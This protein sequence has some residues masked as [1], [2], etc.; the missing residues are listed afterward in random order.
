[1][2]I[3]SVVRE[4]LERA[5]RG[6]FYPQPGPGGA[7]AYPDLGRYSAFVDDLNS[8]VRA[9]GLLYPGCKNPRPW[10]CRVWG[11]VYRRVGLAYNERFAAG[12]T[13]ARVTL[14]CC[15]PPNKGRA[16]ASRNEAAL[17]RKQDAAAAAGRFEDAD[18]NPLPAAAPGGGAAPEPYAWPAD[19][20]GADWFRADAAVQCDWEGIAYSADPRPKLRFYEALTRYLLFEMPLPPS[21]TLLLDCGVLD[22]RWVRQPMRVRIAH[23]FDPLLVTDADVRAALQAGTPGVARRVEFATEHEAPTGFGEADDRMVYHVYDLT[24]RCR[25]SVVVFSGDG[26]TDVAL[27]NTLRVRRALQRSARPEL[28]A[29]RVPDDAP[30]PAVVHAMPRARQTTDPNGARRDFADTIVI[31]TDRLA[32]WLEVHY[33][34]GALA[35]QAGR[36]HPGRVDG[37]AMFSLLVALRTT[38]YTEA[39]PFLSLPNILEAHE[40]TPRLLADALETHVVADPELC[41]PFTLIDCRLHVPSFRRF[42]AAAIAVACENGATRCRAPTEAPRPS[43]AAARRGAPPDEADRL[44][45]LGAVDAMAMRLA[46]L[47]DKYLNGGLPG[48]ELPDPFAC[49]PQS[50][51]SLYGYAR[52]RPPGADRDRIEFTQDV[53]PREWAA[54]VRV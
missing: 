19:E 46:W 32:E 10:H 30:L 6:C 50:G 23:P 26:D 40:R 29:L 36:M 14:D 4:F 12:L 8:L 44:M 7:F 24:V 21:C 9:L 33:G 47:V 18:G 11:D 41:G 49:H 51:K 22:G 17:R 35:A 3:D 20:D 2:G 48:Y 52:T 25:R 5:A 16:Q 28:R 27:V 39:Y 38:D 34:G 43:A 1:M 53:H 45:T 13:E 42:L 31:D 37:G 15:T 54:I